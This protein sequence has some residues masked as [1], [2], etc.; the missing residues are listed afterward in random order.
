LR[1]KFHTVRLPKSFIAVNLSEKDF[2]ERDG[3]G[4]QSDEV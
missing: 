3:L 4:R 1:A 2:G